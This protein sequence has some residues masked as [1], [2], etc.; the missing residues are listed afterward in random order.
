MPSIFLSYRRTDAPGHAGRLYDRLVDRFGDASV[1]KDLD[2]MEPG[3]DFGE[4][5][6]ETVAH[7]DALVAVIGRDW[8]KVE[9]SGRRR[10]DDPQD[11]VHLEIANAL[12]RKIRV[13]PVLVGGALM[14]SAED[15]HEDVQA[16]ARRHAVELTEP[17]WAAQVNQLIDALQRAIATAASG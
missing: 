9:R 1:F 11:W 14:P 3:A 10:L 8:L 6:E 17:A 15:L 16:L 4:V 2:S 13:I 7:C 5:I 12:K